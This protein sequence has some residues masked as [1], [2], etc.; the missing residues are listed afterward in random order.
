MISFFFTK[1][2]ILIKK[3]T[4]R[5][6]LNTANVGL[7]S[8]MFYKKNLNLLIL[9]PK[10]DMG[11]KLKY[12]ILGLKFPFLSFCAVKYLLLIHLQIIRTY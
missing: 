1:L 12:K 8:S 9:L 7:G 11:Y 2:F 5:A 6:I 10:G 3:F 4:T